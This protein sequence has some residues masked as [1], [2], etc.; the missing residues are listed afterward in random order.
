MRRFLS[1]ILRVIARLF[2]RQIQIAGEENVPMREGVIF[3]MNHPNGLVDPLLLLCFAPR[4]VSFL[5][6]APLFR[7]PLVNIFVKGLDSIP[8]YRKR[9]NVAG[10]NEETFSRA[11]EVLARGGSIAI[12][13]E[14]TTH[15]DPKLKEL[16]TG[17]ARIALGAASNELAIVPT[18]IYY[19]E[20][21][22]FRSR[23]LILFGARIAV[24]PQS[25]PEPPR[26]D[27]EHLTAEVQRGLDAV[28]L[29]AE[30]HAVLDL[31]TRAETI[32]SGGES[33]DLAYQLDMRRRFVS[34]YRY[35][36]ERDPDRIAQFT[37]RIERFEADLDRAG[38]SLESLMSKTGFVT[39]TI[40]AVVL[41]PF[42]I[43]GAVLHAVPYALISLL[44]RFSR[45]QEMRA[46]V[47]I[48]AA[49][50][51]YPLTWAVFFFIHPW[52]AVIAPVLGS[53]AVRDFE[54]LALV[55]GRFRAHTTDSKR[56]VDER[57]AIRADF[58]AIADEMALQR[59]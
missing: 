10:S 30:S 11:R 22:T 53:I 33:G 46:T 35:L 56:L 15:S 17:T 59:L 9:D 6:K 58:A 5:A 43:A 28:T 29:Q 26:G 40:V 47:K 13:P 7:Y 27:V 39:R 25:M 49:I 31:I 8:V 36:S 12:F 19:T 2:F 50:V 37:A 21:Q 18:G 4:S 3:A 38:L 1:A 54:E 16:R 14:G 57:T 32:F 55:F 34:G 44:S 51:F 24:Q 23:V 48:L 45:E 20:K 42:A 52:L 41:L